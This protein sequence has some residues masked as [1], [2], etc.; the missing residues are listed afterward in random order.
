MV[1]GLLILSVCGA[2]AKEEAKLAE[3]A[4][5]TAATVQYDKHHSKGFSK[6]LSIILRIFHVQKIICSLLGHT[7]V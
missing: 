3:L 1:K 7:I 2:E 6:A 5:G 4:A